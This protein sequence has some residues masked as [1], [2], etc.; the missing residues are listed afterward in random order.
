VWD[1]L[2]A[3]KRKAKLGNENRKSKRGDFQR[4]TS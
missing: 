3:L 1:R 4:I 2:F